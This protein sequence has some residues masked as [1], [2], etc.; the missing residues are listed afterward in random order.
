MPDLGQSQSL[1]FLVMPPRHLETDGADEP[2]AETT[3]GVAG[4]QLS[5]RLDQRFLPHSG[6]CLYRCF[7]SQRLTS[8][9]ED[10]FVDET[11]RK[12]TASVSRGCPGIVLVT[13]TTYV[14][15]DAR[16]QRLISAPKHVDKP[17]D[18]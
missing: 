11:D 10:L 6:Q 12:T 3:R 1:T 13:S 15:G 18:I 14:S 5:R 2:S 9:R 16:I 8:T 7:A 17:R 4:R